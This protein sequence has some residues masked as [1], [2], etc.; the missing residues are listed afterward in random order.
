MRY[1]EFTPFT[2]CAFGE[3][4]RARNKNALQ[5]DSLLSVYDTPNVAGIAKKEMRL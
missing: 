3:P 1:K 2:S 4:L 5:V